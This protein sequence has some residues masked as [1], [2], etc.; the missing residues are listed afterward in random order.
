MNFTFYDIFI[1]IVLL[2]A[3]IMGYHRGFVL[4]LCG[5]LA[6]FVGL[7]GA[8]MI[9][10][11]LAEPVT[12]FLAP[13]VEGRIT[14]YLT[15]LL[16]DGSAALDSLALP[17]VLSALSD[18]HWYGGFVGALQ[19]LLGSQAAATTTAVVSAIA[20]HVALQ[21][22][23]VVLFVL[24]F[25]A[26]MIAWFLISHALDLACRLPV[27]YTLNHW[28]GAAVGLLKGVLLLFIAA[29][30]LK[31]RFLPPEVVLSSP[32]LHFFCT[33]NPLDFL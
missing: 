4:T 3:L 26:V 13:I 31:D 10:N 6:V 8:V 17:D 29:W 16:P 7:I 15:H 24:S 18:S 22:A 33:T 1:V 20:S 2:A 30:L 25:I 9:S 19:E 21:I 32:L 27:L 5:F 14:A 28:G 11:A 12:G 23:K